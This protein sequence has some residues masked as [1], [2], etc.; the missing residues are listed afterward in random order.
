MKTLKTISYPFCPAALVLVGLSLT[1]C[2]REVPLPAAESLPAVA[3][4]VVAVESRQHQA[5]EEVVGSVQSRQR[6]EI[7]PKVSARVERILVSPGSVVKAGDLL[8]QLDD[9]EI[10][11]RLD[12]AAA[13]LE[14]ANS[15]LG[16]FV[17]LL[18]QETITQ[19]EFDAVRARQRV[20]QASKVEAETM[21]GYTRITAPFDG[22]VS[23]KLAEVGDLAIPGRPLLVIEDPN[24]LRF[25]ADIPEA[26]I[27]RVA[28]GA[29]LRVSVA[30]VN[31]PITGRV[32]EIAPAAD[33]QSRTFRV[34]L[35]LP[36][37][38]GL[39]LGQFGRVAVPVEGNAALRVPASAVLLRGQMEMVFVVEDGTA[40]LRLVKTGKRIGDEVEL[41]SGVEEGERIV[42]S[43]LGQ[44]LDGQPVQVQ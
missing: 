23:R 11:A 29:G 39:R 12:Q 27:G 6:A 30:S 24:A 2:H 21:L 19:A 10:Q 44:M 7:E 15:D 8:A 1:G 36:P 25:D 32:S 5:F 13:T 35:D 38:S 26:L 33:P 31:E 16:R 9:R 34:K 28:V 22:V 14:Q 40:R 20:A 41:L 37:V 42:A 18:K 43:R 17:G 3:V 4:S